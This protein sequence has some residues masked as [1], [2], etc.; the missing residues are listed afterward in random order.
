MNHLTFNFPTA[1][2]TYNIKLS[3][4]VPSTPILCGA[5]CSWSPSKFPVTRKQGWKS[6][7]LSSFRHAGHAVRVGTFWKHALDWKKVSAELL[8]ILVYRCAS[9]LRHIQK[10]TASLVA[11]SNSP[12]FGIVF[13]EAAMGTNAIF[14]RKQNKKKSY[15][16]CNTV[17]SHVCIHN[18][19]IRVIK[20]L[21]SADIV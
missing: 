10:W 12:P 19:Q 2:K 11:P 21:I 17:W 13:Q 18:F 4:V 5:D 1:R 16:F 20:I 15:S 9:P 8:R 6:F 14:R 3:C 7:H